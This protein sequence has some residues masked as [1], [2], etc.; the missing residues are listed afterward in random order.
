M[1]HSL[2]SCSLC[3]VQKAAINALIRKMTKC[4][5]SITLAV[6]LLCKMPEKSPSW[7]WLLHRGEE[8]AWSPGP[9]TLL[10]MNSNYHQVIAT[11]CPKGMCV[12]L[13]SQATQLRELLEKG[14]G[15][16]T[17]ATSRKYRPHPT[18]GDAQW[19]SS[20]SWCLDKRFHVWLEWKWMTMFRACKMEQR[21]QRETERWF[22]D[23]P[24]YQGYVIKAKQDDS[25]CP[26]SH[27]RWVCWSLIC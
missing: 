20:V 6:N 4:S 22:V 21:F 13:F 1:W 26:A 11:K 18:G 9:P 14:M 23:I 16:V 7:G 2:P 19:L 17:F 10:K 15:I 3:S 12:H 5:A 24:L 27:P 8:A 25:S